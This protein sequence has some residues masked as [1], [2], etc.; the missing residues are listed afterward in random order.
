MIKWAF[1]VYAVLGILM[2]W[3]FVILRMAGVYNFKHDS[4]V[5]AILFL[6]SLGIMF[7]TYKRWE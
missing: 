4:V 5:F 7:C 6:I 1:K 2:P 3:A